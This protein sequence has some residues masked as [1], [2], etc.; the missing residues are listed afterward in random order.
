[1]P[2]NFS[3]GFGVGLKP[4]SNLLT[5]QRGSRPGRRGIKVRGGF[6]YRWSNG[7]TSSKTLRAT[8]KNSKP[9]HLCSTTNHQKHAAQTGHLCVCGQAERPVRVRGGSEGERTE[10]PI[11]EIKLLAFCQ[12]AS[13]HI[14]T[15]HVFDSLTSTCVAVSASFMHAYAWLL[16]AWAAALL[17]LLHVLHLVHARACCWPVIIHIL[18]A[19]L[20]LRGRVINIVINFL[21]VVNHSPRAT[22]SS[23]LLSPPPLHLHLM[24]S[25]W[26]RCNG[27]RIL[28]CGQR[29]AKQR[30]S[31][32][33]T[34]KRTRA[35]KTFQE[36][37]SVCTIDE[38]GQGGASD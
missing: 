21:P 6:E 2:C 33:H 17:G 4:C 16:V 19:P 18:A 5:F 38:Q 26:R 15:I 27:P 1:M 3:A 13:I 22:A 7:C 35:H 14:A 8:R 31:Q 11:H 34:H 30:K 12:P 28:S 10:N 25:S 37:Y 9:I 20:P 32:V 29:S 23:A 36:M 24:H